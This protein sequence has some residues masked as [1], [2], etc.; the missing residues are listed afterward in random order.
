MRSSARFALALGL[1]PGLLLAPAGPAATAPQPVIAHAASHPDGRAPFSFDKSAYRGDLRNLPIGVFDSGI[2]GLTVLEAILNLDAF[3]NDTHEPVA[4]GRRDFENERFVYFGDQA[5]MPYGNYPALGREPYLREL[6]LKD[7]L[8]LLGSRYWQEGKDEP[9]FDKPAVKAIV[10]AC[11]TATAYGLEEVRAAFKAWDVPVVTIGVVEAGAQ[12][13]ADGTDGTPGTVAVMATVGTCESEAYPRS[14]ERIIGRAGM[15]P[16]RVIQQGSIGLAGAIEG[17][18]AFVGGPQSSGYQ[19]PGVT[20]ASARLPGQPPDHFGFDPEGL[21]GNPDQQATLRLNSVANYVRYDVGT[22]VENFRKQGG[23]DPIDTVVLGCTHFP[24]VGQEIRDAF[25]RLRDLEVSGSTPYRA[26]IAETIRFVNPA[27]Q[28]AKELYRSLALTRALLRSDEQPSIRRDAFFIS[29]PNPASPGVRLDAGGGL[30]RDYKYGRDPGQLDI[31]DTRNV[32]MR[33][34][35]L[36][37]PSLNLVRQKLPAVWSRL[38]GQR[39]ESSREPCQRL[40]NPLKDSAPPAR[41]DPE[42]WIECPAEA[43]PASP[44][45]PQFPLE[46]AAR[47]VPSALF[48]Q[49]GP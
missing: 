33:A 45:R 8:F 46:P 44:A 4:D 30:A 25:T 40:S 26:L 17:D 7:A 36:P 47:A 27:E 18:P 42:A 13:V 37:E 41:D 35:M 20:I 43:D 29:L 14:I 48:F 34:A 16:P 9:S 38:G 6:V 32:P 31:E 3:D 12:G 15:T 21:L 22:L 28:T 39:D 23:G 5:N 2:G 24:L 49:A 19:G 10:I 1:L 11:N